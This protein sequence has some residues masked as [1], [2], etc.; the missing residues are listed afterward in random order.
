MI[1]AYH[2]I[3]VE[4]HDDGRMQP[5]MESARLVDG[6]KIVDSCMAGPLG[7][8]AEA[9]AQVLRAAD[10]VAGHLAATPV[11][12]WRPKAVEGGTN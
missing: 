8:P 4:I 9:G 6:V 12:P 5:R 3:M 1:V 11:L 7:T 2:A 10:M